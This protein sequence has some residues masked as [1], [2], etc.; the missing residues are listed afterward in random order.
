[1]EPHNILDYIPQRPPFVMIDQIKEVDDT[2]TV[3]TFIIRNDNYFV[4]NGEFYEG[5]LIENMAQTIAA[6]AGYRLKQNGGEPKMGVIASVRKLQI[7][8]RPKENDELTTKVE[9]I[10]DF[11]TA[12]VVKGII[13]CNQEEIASGQMNVFVID[14]SDMLKQK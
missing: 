12:L 6:G 10:S 5:G 2:I 11:G 1:M 13:E 3:S 9:L 7:N 4:D 8:K 14:N